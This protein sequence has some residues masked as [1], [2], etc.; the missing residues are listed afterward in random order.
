MLACLGLLYTTYVGC[1]CLAFL[2]LDLSMR[3]A[4]ERRTRWK[5]LIVMLALLTLAY[6]PGFLAL[7]RQ[8]T[9]LSTVNPPQSGIR[10]FVWG[11]FNLYVLFASESI[12]PWGWS[13]SIPIG[14][15][16]LVIL[17]IVMFKSAP[18]T[19]L[20]LVFAIGMVAVLTV[21]GVANTK[22]SAVRCRY[23]K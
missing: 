18:R 21:L 23:V 12:A 1:A 20:M 3:T 11:S 9:S 14:L 4:E 2:G 7:S 13:S 6:I 15:A 19:R 10:A 5:P 17:V 22:R 16:I 8:L